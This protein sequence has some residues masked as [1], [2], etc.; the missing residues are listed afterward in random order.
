MDLNQYLS[1]PPEPSEHAEYFRKYIIRVPQG[2]IVET[3]ESGRAALLALLAGIPEG[4]GSYRYAADKWTLKQALGHVNDTERV[5]GYRSLRIGRGDT[6][7]LPG[8][9][10]DVLV[11]NSPADSMTIAELAEEFDLIRRGTLA[12]VRRFGIEDW[13]RRGTASGK[14]VSVRALAYMTAGHELHHRAI[15]QERYLG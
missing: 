1:T 5:F 12:L 7:P 15:L 14:E 11:V 13:Q 6:T 9:D 3:L 2:N 8:F 4:R 10:Q